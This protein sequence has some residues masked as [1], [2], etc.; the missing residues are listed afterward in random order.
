MPTCRPDERAGQIGRADLLAV[1]NERRVVLGTI[2]GEA[3]AKAAPDATAEELMHHQPPTIRPDV[4]IEQI[5]ERYL[6]ERRYLL[7]T[8]PD[9]VLLGVVQRD[10][11]VARPNA[12]HHEHG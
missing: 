9:G 6:G 2:E 12:H 8:N 4:P 7:V 11:V 5:A 10:D 3:L 1:V